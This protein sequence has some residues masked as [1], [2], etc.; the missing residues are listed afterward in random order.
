M[1]EQEGDVLACNLD[2]K[3]CEKSHISQYFG[4]IWC[5]PF[6]FIS[7]WNTTARKKLLTNAMTTATWK[8]KKRHLKRSGAKTKTARFLS[9]RNGLI[10][11]LHHYV[12]LTKHHR[13]PGVVYAVWCSQ[14]VGSL[15]FRS[16]TSCLCA[17]LYAWIHS[18]RPHCC[19]DIHKQAFVWLTRSS[20]T[21]Q[22]D[23]CSLPLFQGAIVSSLHLRQ[24]WSTWLFSNTITHC[25]FCTLYFCVT[26]EST[27]SHDY[28]IVWKD[29]KNWVLQPSPL[30]K[31]SRHQ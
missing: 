12:G 31:H 21:S 18:A 14:N 15:I 30:W 23:T 27:S 7:V 5:P 3:S 13:E 10:I 11:R 16:Q 28:N 24:K 17:S 9:W 4:T 19:C 6:L 29:N 8:K 25:G 20:H 1:N 22:T 2:R 26:Y